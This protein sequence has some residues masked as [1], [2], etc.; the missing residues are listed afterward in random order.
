LKDGFFV[1]RQ[2][3]LVRLW[4]FF[5]FSALSALSAFS[6][7]PAQTL[8]GQIVLADSTT[9]AP[10]A[11]VVLH[12]VG[13]ETQGPIDSARADTRGGFRFDVK[14]DTSAFYLVSSRRSGIEYFSVPIRVDSRRAG[15]KMKVV[16]YDTSSNVPVTLEARHLVVTS[17]TQDGSRSVLDLIVLR[18]RTQ[19]TRVAPDSLRPSWS[20]RLPAGT[21]GLELGESDISSEAVT[22]LGDSLLVLAPLAPGEKQLTVEYLVR[23]GRTT[24]EFPMEQTAGRV[25]I[26][27]EERDLRVIEANFALVDSQVIRGRAFHRWTGLVSAS[28][29]VRVELPRG[30]RGLSW[31][32]P[33]LVL[34]LALGLAGG[35]WFLVRRQPSRLGP[36]SEELVTAIALLDARYLGLERDT[37]ADEWATYQ[38]ERSRLKEKLE[39]S[40]ATRRSGR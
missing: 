21:T 6:P 7:L 1:S 16:V 25:N 27:A 17:P 12:R 23:P 5:A 8:T 30:S 18:N 20:T 2:P 3:I 36:R 11:K 22:R 10:G 33:T 37:P 14:P 38:T 19:L 4:T 35:A 34:A 15:R 9:G 26:L 13:P 40:L 39:A 24:L 29:V 28:G 32:L 31:L